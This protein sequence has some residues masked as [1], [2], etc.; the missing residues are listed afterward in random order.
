MNPLFDTTARNYLEA[1]HPRK[2]NLYP[3]GAFLVDTINEGAAIAFG[4]STK[5]ADVW[6]LSV[7]TAGVVGTSQRVT[8]TA[9]PGLNNCLQ[10]VVTTPQNPAAADANIFYTA[11]EGYDFAHLMWGSTAGY[12]LAIGFWVNSTVIGEYSVVIGGGGGTRNYLTTFQVAAA[13]TWEF[14]TLMIPPETTAV[15]NK[16]E[17]AGAFLVFDL[18]S[19]V[20]TETAAANA[21]TATTPRRSPGTVKIISQ[22][23]TFRIAGVRA[24]LGYVDQATPL[25]PVGDTIL[26]CLRYHPSVAVG[27]FQPGLCINAGNAYVPVPLIVPAMLAPSNLV[28]PGSA[29]LYSA[30]GAPI[31]TTAHSLSATSKDSVVVQVSVAAGLV[32]GNSTIY[33]PATTPR[34]LFT[35]AELV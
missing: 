7:A 22:A 10:L 27:A 2:R 28:A 26:R 20:N 15:W 9:P 30:A 21:W 11:I 32:A 13:N 33:A 19:G 25:D 3:N 29:N 24:F 17:S 35:G 12:P 18:G 16:V 31:A 23:C 4:A 5:P 1:V 8:G 6:R 34:L 14:K